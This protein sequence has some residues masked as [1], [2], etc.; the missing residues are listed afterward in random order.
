MH[1]YCIVGQYGVYVYIHVT[2]MY[3]ENFA[4]QSIPFLSKL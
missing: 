2:T 4:E 1:Y 3:L